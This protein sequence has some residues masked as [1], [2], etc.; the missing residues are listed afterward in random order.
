LT[1]ATLD[2]IIAM[3]VHSSG[4]IFAGNRRGELLKIAPNGIQFN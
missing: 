3:A 1:V 4:I 2:N